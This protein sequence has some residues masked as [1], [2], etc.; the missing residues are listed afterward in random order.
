MSK[1]EIKNL[2]IDFICE[3]DFTN[4]SND[5]VYEKFSDLIYKKFTDLETKLAL[6]EKALEL[7]CRELDCLYVSCK[8]NDY[9][10]KEESCCIICEVDFKKEKH[11]AEYFKTKAKEMMKSDTSL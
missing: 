9:K 11:L 2:L 6:T 1:E 10:C 8:F 4:W 5:K 3:Y 7:A